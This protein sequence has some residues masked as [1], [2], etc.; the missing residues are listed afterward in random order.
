MALLLEEKSS[1]KCFGGYIKVYTHDSNEVNTKM[2][3]AVYLPPLSESTKCPVLYWL[4]G[5]T[6]TEQNFITKSGFQ[7]Y[8]SELGIIVVCPDTSPRGANIEGENDHWDFG[9]GAA[10]YVD[11][12]EEKWKKNYRMY[13]Y[14]TKELPEIIENNFP[15]IKNAQSIFGHSVGG[16]GALIC[17][18]KNPGKFRSVSV[19]A[20]VSNPINSPWGKK[21]F[22]AFLG[23]EQETW[24]EYDACELGKQYQG[25]LIN[26][27]IDQGTVDCFGK[28]QLLTENFVKVCDENPMLKAKFRLQEGYDHNFYFVSTFIEEHIRY[29][30]AALLECI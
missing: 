12:T 4:S 7:K 23:P 15:V 5:L 20:P 13:S 28:D 11:A 6:C 29:H 22:T 21:A 10:Y 16:H 27:L 2:S 1:S 19:F 8:A 26:I 18:L 30:A 14:V 17:A 25:P 24:K 3:F 9:I